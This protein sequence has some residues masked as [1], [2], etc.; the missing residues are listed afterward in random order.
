M[1]TWVTPGQLLY[2]GWSLER[3]P[4]LHRCREGLEA[5]EGPGMGAGLTLALPFATLTAKPVARNGVDPFASGSELSEQE[6]KTPPQ[7][8]ASQSQGHRGWR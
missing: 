2:P 4:S 5:G 3:V 6:T 8:P 1:E 7:L